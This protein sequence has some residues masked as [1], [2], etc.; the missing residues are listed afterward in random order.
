[1]IGRLET[2]EQQTRIALVIWITVTIGICIYGGMTD[3]SRSVTGAYAT[4][5]QA[6]VD[7]VNVFENSGSELHGFLYL[8]Q[9]AMLWAPLTMLPG[10]IADPLWRVITI[11]LFAFGCWRFFRV[12]E[13]RVEA[14]MILLMTALTI[15][16]ALSGMRN[17]QSTLP[18]TGTM[19]LGCASL[20]SGHWWRATAWLMLALVF[21]PL[22]I[23]LVLVAWVVYPPMWWR[24]PLGLIAFLLTPF[25]A[26]TPGYV[27]EFY[28][29]FLAKAAAKTQPGLSEEADTFF[30]ADISALIR[31]A[32]ITLSEGVLLALRLAAAGATLG[33]SWWSLKR[34]GV[35]A[36]GLLTASWCLIWLVLFNPA[37]EN[38]T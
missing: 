2:R 10:D 36:G 15:P 27:V 31:F 14:P 35:I 6:W 28:G 5:G 29:G 3:W 18:M 7:G 30:A 23:A 12:A 4:G 8:P 20:M 1:M 25:L 17:G 19:L 22:A 13:A 32:G 11:G 34:H 16:A 21:K 24:M 38:N 33:L 9:S 37:T 26:A